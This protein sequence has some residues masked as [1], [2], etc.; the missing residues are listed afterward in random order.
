[1]L[2]VVAYILAGILFLLAGANQTI[3]NLNG[4]REIGWGLFFCV[5][6]RLLGGVGPAL[7][8]GTRGD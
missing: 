1:M 4:L 2:S 6:A 5:V 7:N 8:Y 3:F